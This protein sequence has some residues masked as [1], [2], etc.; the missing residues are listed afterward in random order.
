M[1]NF[2]KIRKTMAR[3]LFNEGKSIYLLPCK[4]RVNNMWQ[5]PYEMVKNEEY[6]DFDK[7]VNNYEYYNCQYNET[8]KYTA[9]YILDK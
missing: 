5:S 4:M 3:K 2:L 9:F 6:P 8:G 1:S 7:M